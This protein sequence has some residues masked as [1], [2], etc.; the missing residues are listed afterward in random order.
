MAEVFGLTLNAV[1]TLLIYIAIGYFLRRHHDLPDEAGHVLS[2]LCTLLFSPAYSIINLSRNFTMDVIGEKMLILGY[3]VLFV[4]AA[5]GLSYLLSK[6]FSKDKNEHNSMIY[7]FA[8]PNFGY[9]GYPVIQA[10]FGDAMLADVMV[11]VIPLSFATNSIGYVLFMQGRKIPWKTVLISPMVLSVF[12]GA[13]IGISGLQ[14]PPMVEGILTG[15]GNCMSP[16]SMLL[17]GFMLGKFPLNK[18]LT[19]IRPY[20]L[21]AVRLLLVPLIFGAIL[22]FAGIRGL[23]LMLPLLITGLPL[24]MNLVVYP[25]SQGQERIASDNAKL[26]FI[27][28]LLSVAV[29]PI[30]FAVL[31]YLTQ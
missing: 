9:F 10:V 16:A 31:A 1:G 12:I 5:F 7:A 20:C 21:S 26:C 3:G 24:G 22:W 11:F 18:L 29:L 19:G 28:Y 4:F 6:P 25:E 14:M 23:Y 15:L 13:I 8:I 17:A 2:L 30:T 27:S